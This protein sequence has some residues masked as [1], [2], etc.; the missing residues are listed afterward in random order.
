MRKLNY[1]GSIYW[2]AGGSFSPPKKK[3]FPK[4]KLKAIQILILFHDDIKESMK[5]TNVQKWD[6]RQS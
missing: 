1:Q 3:F 4:K 5:V 6:F 2:G